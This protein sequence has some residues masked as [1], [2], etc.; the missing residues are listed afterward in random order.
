MR[1][2]WVTVRLR[3]WREQLLPKVSQVTEG[4]SGQNTEEENFFPKVAQV[5]FIEIL[6]KKS[7]I[8][9]IL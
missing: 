4:N 6:K 2:C 3:L 8:C 5:G 1:L 7:A 9:T